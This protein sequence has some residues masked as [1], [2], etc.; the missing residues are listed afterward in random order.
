M[1][2]RTPLNRGLATRRS[3]GLVLAVCVLCA[4]TVARAV[5]VRVP[6]A[7]AEL[8]WMPVSIEIA[9]DASAD[10]GT[11]SVLLNGNDI[12]S[13]FAFGP[14]S[15]GEVVAAAADVW[16]G[17]VILGSNQIDVSI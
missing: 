17:F 14:P 5:E 10:T 12:S 4:G 6:A 13:A 8:T 7:G 11:L 3:I 1:R 2:N 9:F 16:D 15:G